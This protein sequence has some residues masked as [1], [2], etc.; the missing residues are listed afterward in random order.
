MAVVTDYHNN[1]SNSCQDVSLKTTNVNLMVA[2]VRGTTSVGFILWWTWMS[3]QNWSNVWRYFSLV[4]KC[5]NN[6]PTVQ[7][8]HPSSHDCM[9]KDWEREQCDN[10]T[11]SHRQHFSTNVFAIFP[12]LWLLLICIAYIYFHYFGELVAFCIDLSSVLWYMKVPVNLDHE[13]NNR[14]LHFPSVLPSFSKIW[15]FWSSCTFALLWMWWSS[16]KY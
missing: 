10:K 14:E 2:K 7:Q 1:P 15:C 13:N 11:Y 6:R 4:K 9:T 5:W 12:F 16:Q 3:V 8:C